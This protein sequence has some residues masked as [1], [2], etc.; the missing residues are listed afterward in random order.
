MSDTKHKFELEDGLRLC[1]VLE[2][3]LVENGLHCALAGSLVYKGWSDKD[4][5]IFIYNHDPKDV[6]ST[7]PDIVLSILKIAFK[8]R[9][10]LNEGQTGTKYDG[11]IKA[12]VIGKTKTYIVD[13]FIITK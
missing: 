3:I 11:I 12:K 2:P 10:E 1:R 4:I 7:E 6:K 5:D 9:I 13:F 8:K